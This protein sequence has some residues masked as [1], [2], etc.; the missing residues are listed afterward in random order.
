MPDIDQMPLGFQTLA[1]CKKY[2]QKWLELLAFHI[3][4]FG[5]DRASTDAA[6]HLAA[7]RAR[8]RHSLRRYVER[9]LLAA[10][11]PRLK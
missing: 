4:T 8:I 1:A 6:E 7:I 5:Y 9:A 10:C 3:V 2:L 11:C